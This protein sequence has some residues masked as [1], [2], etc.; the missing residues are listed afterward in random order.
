MYIIINTS[1]DDMWEIVIDKNTGYTEFFETKEDA[2]E[3]ADSFLVKD[4]YRI[5]ST[6]GE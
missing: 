1:N 4:W 5:V 3:Y 2:Q 6:I